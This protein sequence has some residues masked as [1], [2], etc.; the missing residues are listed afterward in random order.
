MVLPVITIDFVLSSASQQDFLRG[1][2]QA[3]LE[4]SPLRVLEETGGAGSSCSS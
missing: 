1:V 2:L 4:A 3:I